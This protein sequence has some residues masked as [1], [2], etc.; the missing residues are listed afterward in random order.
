MARERASGNRDRPRTYTCIMIIALLI[1]L[2]VVAGLGYL[3]WR[4]G[5]LRLLLY[6]APLMGASLGAVWIGKLLFLLGLHHLTGLVGPPAV[7]LVIG[8]VLGGIVRWKLRKRLPDKEHMHQADRIGGAV[9]AAFVA[10]IVLWVGG[11]FI[12]L[13]IIQSRHGEAGDP[14][15]AGR[16]T[17]ALSNSVVRHVPGV[18]GYAHDLDLLVEFASTSDAAK[19]AAVDE[20]NLRDIEDLPEMQAILDDEDTVADVRAAQSGSVMAI[21]RLQNNPLILD[22]IEHPDIR[23]LLDTTTIEDLTDRAQAYDRAA[24]DES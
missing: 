19:Q 9:F 14:T 23:A 8:A 18:G 15:A 6:L 20:L 12:D 24:A 10:V 11:V 5:G 2:I 17:R 21:M 13:L 3:G 7:G 1:A 4:V 16:L 22:F